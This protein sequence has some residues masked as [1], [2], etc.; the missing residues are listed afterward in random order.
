MGFD[1][2]ITI[3]VAGKGGTGK[4]T[5]CGMLISHLVISKKGHIL[6]VDADPNS[7]LNEVL[8]VQAPTSLGEIRENMLDKG[9]GDGLPAGMTKQEYVEFMFGDALFEED[10]YDLL[11]MGRT[12]GA[13]CYCYV[14]GVLKTQIDRY[15]GSYSHIIVDNE[16]G[17]EH[18]SRGTLPK[19][20]I[21]VLVSD[22]S[23]RGIQA[24][25]RVAGIVREL[26][27][28]PKVMKLV[29]NRAPDGELGAG[30]LEEI[31][32]QSLDLL[33]VLPQDENVYRYDSDGLPSSSVPDDSPV[34][35]AFKNIITKL[36]L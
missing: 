13:G 31:R 28:N 7:N 33:G 27:L 29:V 14:N 2:P 30:V 3:A 15:S 17:L 34:K 4:T 24:A 25:G 1:M 11:V 6:A 26:K 20:D 5:F 18:I 23:R 22:C 32:A 36:E 35:V 10:D 12:Q 19:V 21:L 8:G 9:A 16:A